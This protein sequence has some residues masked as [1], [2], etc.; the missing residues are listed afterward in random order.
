MKFARHNNSEPDWK[1]IALFERR[2]AYSFKD[3]ALLTLALRHSSFVHEHPQQPE[4]NERLEFLGDAVI[5][6][7][8]T[9]RLFR[10][11]PKLQEGE[12]SRLRAS[13]IRTRSLAEL[14][15]AWGLGEILLLGRSERQS[16][17]AEKPSI[18]E[19]ALEALIGAVYLDAGLEACRA[20]LDPWIREKAA[21]HNQDGAIDDRTRLQQIL[22]ARGLPVPDYKV[23]LTDGPPHK[24]FYHVIVQY[25]GQI[26]G[27]GAGSSN[28]AAGQAAAHD[29]LLRMGL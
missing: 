26:L 18:L 14:A 10:D 27:C 11:Y 24:R 3:R 21:E 16:H 29:A 1:A 17:G 2:I 25:S 20:V 19:C 13:L 22:Q 7:L 9:E 23:V 8:V 12:L 5:E 6:I 15:R 4:S 28:K